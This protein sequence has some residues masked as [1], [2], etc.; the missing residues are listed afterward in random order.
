MHVAQASHLW[1]GL[2]FLAGALAASS[3]FAAA[4]DNVIVERDVVYGEADG[5]D[6]KLDLIRPKKQGDQPLPAIVWI[7]G[8]GWKKGS[9]NSGVGTGTRYAR[10][11]K[12][13]CATVGYRLS[14][15][16]K[17]P[18]QIHDCKAAIRWLKKNAGKYNIDKD[19]IGVWGSSAGGHLTAMM[20]TTANLEAFEG[21]SGNPDESTQIACGV[22]LA[23]VGDFIA[24]KDF[25]RKSWGQ[26]NS[27]GGAEHDLFGHPLDQFEEKVRSASPVNHASR[28]DPPVLIV[29][30]ENDPIVPFNQA[31]LLHR[32]LQEAGVNVTFIKVVKG[33]HGVAGIA[34]RRID[35]FFARHLLGEEDSEVSEEP[36]VASRTGSSTR[37]LAADPKTAI[38]K[39][40][41]SME[42]GS[43]A[44]LKTEGFSQLAGVDGELM[45]RSAESVVWLPRSQQVLFA[46]PGQQGTPKFLSYSAATNQWSLMPDPSWKNR[47][48]PAYDNNAADPRK[49]SFYHNPAGSLEVHYF[50][51]ARNSWRQLRR[52]P[53]G[54]TKGAGTALVYSDEMNGLVRVAGGEVYF[55]AREVPDWVLLRDDLPI[56]DSLNVAEYVPVH[57]TLVLGGGGN[58][59]RLYKLSRKESFIEL[60]APPIDEVAVGKTVLTSDPVSGDLLLFEVGARRLHSYDFKTPNW[61]THDA[62]TAPFRDPARN[63]AATPI[64]TY[65]V[66]FF[67]QEGNVAVLYKHES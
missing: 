67:I 51:L 17:W 21:E 4:E 18:S 61:K 39:L 35:A 13:V 40:A 46:G 64:D 5:V 20:A 27:P 25:P 3:A 6:L 55:L 42:P 57:K 33:G 43:W 9:K 36:L 22:V 58:C 65:G 28:D 53:A 41:N 50:P 49:D 16:S 24:Y 38:G 34:S 8:G 60:P 59:S 63:I 2:S 47:A 29:H 15:V 31:E 44:E 54:A 30:G 10:T 52:L 26:P 48:A 1:Y 56:G 14:G 11:G 66:V 23:G 45:F 12:Y 7:H 19:R 32:A 37:R 62:R